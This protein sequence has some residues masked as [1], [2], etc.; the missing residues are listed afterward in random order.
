MTDCATTVPSHPTYLDDEIAALGLQLEEINFYET[1]RKGKY[2]VDHPPDAEV[3]YANFQTELETYRGFLSD[4]KLARSIASAVDTDAR[5]IAGIVQEEAEARDDR[6]MAVQI[7]HDDP[8]IEAAPLSVESELR[9]TISDWMS[10]VSETIAGNT[11]VE[12]SDDEDEA[13]SSMSYSER[14]ADALGNLFKSFQCCVCC[15]S[16]QSPFIIKLKCG[17]RFC[18]GC[19]KELFVRASRDETLFPVRCHKEPIP[20]ALIERSMTTDELEA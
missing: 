19:L 17:D 12:Y 1:G 14:Q 15:E 4:Q 10:T 8:E 7:S 6:R 18:V 16:F 5:V 9:G 13:G 2:A 3:A 20:L 11:V